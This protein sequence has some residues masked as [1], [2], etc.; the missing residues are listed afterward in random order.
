[1]SKN[2]VE[3]T[4]GCHV[5]T[6]K[7]RVDVAI[8]KGSPV[9]FIDGDYLV[10]NLPG[11]TGAHFSQGVALQAHTINVAECIPVLIPGPV[12]RIISGAVITAG[13]VVNGDFTTP[14]EWIVDASDPAGF[15]LQSEG[16]GDEMDICFVG[17]Q[18]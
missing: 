14:G 11:G 17:E 4:E 2:Q 1:M 15:A 18:Y 5:V 9:V 7:A 12:L 16:D 8:P 3:R 6:C 10:D 13:Q